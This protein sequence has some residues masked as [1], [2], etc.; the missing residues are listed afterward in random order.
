L[1][2]L[3]RGAPTH[4]PIRRFLLQ[5]FPYAIAYQVHPDLTTVL[6]IVHGRR[7]PLYWVGRAR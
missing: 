5:R 4:P 6:A 3:A 2:T 1:G 7:R